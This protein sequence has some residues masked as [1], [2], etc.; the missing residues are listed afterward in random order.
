MRNNHS[1]ESRENEHVQG[2]L[3]AGARARASCRF[4]IRLATN[5]RGYDWDGVLGE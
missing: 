4:D 5:D 2:A 3:V 1:F